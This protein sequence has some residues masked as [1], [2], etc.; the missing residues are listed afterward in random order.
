MILAPVV[1][2]EFPA[3]VSFAVS[4]YDMRSDARLMNGSMAVA[5]N[6]ISLSK[7]WNEI[8]VQGGAYGAV[9]SA[10]RTGSLLCYTYRDPS[11]ARSLN[12]YKTIPEFLSELASQDAA[13]LDGF[14]ISTVASTE[15]LLSPA[16]KG[17]AAD[18]FYLSG[19]S[20]GDRIRFRTEMLD[21]SAADLAAQLD[22]LEG[23]AEK[24]CI[25]VVG[26]K[27]ALD[28]CEGLHVVEL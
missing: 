13:D 24:S 12:I 10:G 7:L 19:F 9:M 5:S 6:I 11:P 14:I 17:R 27:A 28:E 2:I 15:P 1:A 18:D 20:D 25:C 8:R 26:P 3:Q 22:A 16:A 4:S 21:T 23:M